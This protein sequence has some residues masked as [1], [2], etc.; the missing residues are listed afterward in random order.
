MGAALFI[1][2]CLAVSL[3]ST[4]QVYF[5]LYPYPHMTIKMSYF[6]V[7][8]GGRIWGKNTV[9]YCKILNISLC[10]ASSTSC[11]CSSITSCLPH[12]LYFSCS[13]LL[14]VS[15]HTMVFHLTHFSYAV[16]FVCNLYFTFPTKFPG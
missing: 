4:H 12:L 10:I 11:I 8:A 6:S 1:G 15:Q 14:S 7:N 13:S 5:M 2:G 16:P 3:D 9:N